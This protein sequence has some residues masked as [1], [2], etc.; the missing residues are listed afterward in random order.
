MYTVLCAVAVLLS[1]NSNY[2]VTNV[3]IILLIVIAAVVAAVVF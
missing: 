2:P 3:S 1:P